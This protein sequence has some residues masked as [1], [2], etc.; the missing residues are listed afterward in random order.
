MYDSVFTPLTVGALSLAN[1]IIMA[2]LTRL[3]NIEPGD[4]PSALAV[5][6]YA[7]R[8]SAG[9][10]ITEATHISPT[11]KG[12][13]GAPGIYN[14]EH[15]H[16]WR[17]VTEAVHA[18]KGRIALQLWH[19]GRIS[20]R[21]V[22]PGHQAP[23]APS[24]LKANSNTNIRDAHGVLVR[25]PCDEP[26]ALTL[27]EIGQIIDDYCRATHY[28]RE[29]GFD[30]VEIHAAHGYLLDQF[31]SPHVNQRTDD[32]GGCIENRA[33]LI[34]E[35]VDAI[36]SS[37]NTNRV[38]IRLS[39]LGTFNDIT[40][41]EEDGMLAYLLPALAKR[42]LAYLHLSE[43]EWAGGQLYSDA[44]RA[45]LREAYPGILIA[46]GNYTVEKAARLITQGYIDAAA[47]GRSYI[48]NPDLVERLR[49]HAPLAT[50]DPST[51]YGGGAHGYT[52]YPCYHTGNT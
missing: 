31:L 39:P 3:R 42:K 36:A 1:R 28:A 25:A 17:A 30:Y 11:A 26:R 50:P 15:V 40:H 20:H 45:R 41:T 7:Q 5:T 24:A 4:I 49:T 10:L 27:T 23:V 2:P 32:Y 18:A 16:A 46:A 14:R 47:F 35:V 44:L 29:A 21:S 22:Q 9:L 6:Y 43:A 8:A 48:A 52:D 38:G 34:L 13:A 37:W 33:R 12:Y 51:Y 19:T